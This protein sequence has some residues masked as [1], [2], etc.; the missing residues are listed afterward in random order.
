MPESIGYERNNKIR[1]NLS[2]DMQRKV[3]SSWD[4]LLLGQ[5]YRQKMREQAWRDAHVQYMGD[6]KWTGAPDDETADLVSVNMSFSTLN[7]L[8]P[9][10]SDEDPKFAITPYSRDASEENAVLIEAFMNR[11]WR[12]DELAGQEHIREATFDY[13]QLGDGFLKVGYNIKPLP[14]FDANGEEVES[15]VDIADFSVERVNPWDIWVDPFSDGIHNARWVCQRIMMPWREL[16]NDD[17]YKIP[18]DIEASGIDTNNMSP[19]DRSRLEDVDNWVTVYEFY[20]L[21]EEW[22]ISLLPGGT[23]AIRYI[24]HVQV[25]LVQLANY[26][27]P[28]SPYHM[29]ELEQISSLQDELNKTRSQMITHRRRNA[30]KWLVREGALEDEAWEAIKSGKV[31]DIIP[32]R[33]TDPFDQIVAPI[34][35]TP[36]SSDAYAMDAQMRADINEITGVNEY[37]RGMPQNISRTATEATIIEGATNIRTRHKLLQVETAAKNVG[38]LLLNIIRDVLPLTRFQEMTMYVT[39]RDAEKLNRATGQ[40]DVYTNVRLTPSPEIFQGKYIVEVERGSTELRNPEQKAAKLRDM[41]QMMI[42]AMPLLAQSGVFFDLK[43]LLQLWL[44]AEGI[45]DVDSLFEPDDDQVQAQQL[46]LMQQFMQSPPGEVVAGGRTRPGS[47]RPQT[48][49][50]PSDRINEGN[51]GILPER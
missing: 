48:T 29:G 38:Q 15:D 14:V 4:R 7:T 16:E 36:I 50:P 27:I 34:H 49:N 1:S 43:E 32:V 19:E 3:K 44:E 2:K 12:S 13:L 10:V 39:G 24:E 45:E 30:A 22:M 35:A 8:V 37:L 17:R 47:P 9:F 26:R 42:S 40:E 11:L 5:N 18:K 25:P 20:D 28:N 51:S 33:G 6:T 31:N 46:G 21:V 41:A 23:T